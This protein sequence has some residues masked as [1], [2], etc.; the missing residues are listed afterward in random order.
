MQT[1]AE[2]GIDTLIVDTLAYFNCK[3]SLPTLRD[4]LEISGNPVIKLRIATAIFDIGQDPAMADI[5]VALVKEMDNKKA[6]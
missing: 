5:A 6:A 3:P 4:L 1:E 2:R